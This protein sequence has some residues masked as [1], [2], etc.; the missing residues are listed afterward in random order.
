M[1]RPLVRRL[2]L[3]RLLLRSGLFLM[4]PIFRVHLGRAL[5]RFAGGLVRFLGTLVPLVWCLLFVRLLGKKRSSYHQR[6]AYQ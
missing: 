1:I 4:I 2:P 6:T 5:L 3:F